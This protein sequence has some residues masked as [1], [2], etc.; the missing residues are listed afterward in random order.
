V[1]AGTEWG[2]Q[3]SQHQRLTAG[4][5]NT[6]FVELGSQSIARAFAGVGTSA[7]WRYAATVLCYVPDANRTE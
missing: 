1:G 5:F 6:F 4:T 3:H 7:W 2:T